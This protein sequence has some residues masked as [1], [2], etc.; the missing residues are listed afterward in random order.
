VKSESDGDNYITINLFCKHNTNIFVRF[1]QD[2]A[3]TDK[4]L[5]QLLMDE[6]KL[7]NAAP[8]KVKLAF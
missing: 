2:E 5:E 1:T 7:E 3:N 4:I 6:S 8:E